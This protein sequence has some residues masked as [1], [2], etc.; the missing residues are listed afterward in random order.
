[1]SRHLFLVLSCTLLALAACTSSGQPTLEPASKITVSQV[2]SRSAGAPASAATV[3][4]ALPTAAPTLPRTEMA[5]PT[6]TAPKA[7]KN[8]AQAMEQIARRIYDVSFAHEDLEPYLNGVMTAF[9]IPPLATD[10]VAQAESRYKRGLP[11]IF[12]PQLA[13][14]ADAFYN[15]DLYSL[16]SFIA[17]ANERGVRQRG[18]NLPLTHEYLTLKFA[19]Y[20]E[21][22][23]YQVGQALPAF[24]LA[25]GKERA[26]RSPSAK[27]DPLWGDELLDPLQ[28]ML[29]IYSVSY[30]GAKPVPPTASGTLQPGRTA[31]F[32]RLSPLRSPVDVPSL[33]ADNPLLDWIMDQLGGEVTGEIQEQI[34][35]PIDEQDAAQ[36]SLCASLLLYG[37]KTEVKTEPNQIYH[38][39]G[40]RPAVT[41]VS[42]TVRFQDD[43]YSQTKPIDRWLIKTLGN[44]ELPV[45]GLARGVD[46]DWSVSDGLLK[47]GSY[48]YAQPQTDLNGTAWASWRTV[49]ETTPKELRSFYTQRDAVGAAIV[50][51]SGLIPGWGSLEKI[52][53]LLRDTGAVGQS[54]L[55]VMYYEIPAYR[56]NS[57]FGLYSKVP[58]MGDICALDKPFTL[59]VDG[60]NPSGG[61]YIGTFEFT[62]QGLSGG[63]WV[64]AAT[65]C[66]IPSGK[67]G[68]E[69]G[70]STF[71][72]EGIAEGKPVLKMAATTA[73]SALD[74]YVGTWP[75]PEWQIELEPITGTCKPK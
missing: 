70:S 54:T 7:P 17:A 38:N 69:S 5:F 29:L 36:V 72:V 23:Q 74:G 67:C 52:V 66:M 30:A 58:V 13:Q 24:V 71:R 46:L 63:S 62:P 56:V 14:M 34:E 9:G 3:P 75:W 65:S 44:C 8:S 32:L 22:N 39:D 21:K 47:H 33:G 53:N 4:L 16:D 11:L 10:D 60:R 15:G 48:D 49:P 35:I 59:K 6:P 51:V 50:R 40:S 42:V 73:S 37:Y 26:R 1:M 43:Y 68:A 45:Q 61:N 19:S 25:L 57:V 18:T 64:H 55:T 20:A 2:V 28:T 41:R 12:R 31:G 27:L